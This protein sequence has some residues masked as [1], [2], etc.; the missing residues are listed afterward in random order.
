MRSMLN[1]AATIGKAKVSTLMERAP[2]NPTIGIISRDW[3]KR[4]I[5][6]FFELFKVPWG[7]YDKE[8]DY[9]IIIVTDNTAAVPAARLVFI[10]SAESTPFDLHEGT[11]VDLHEGSTMLQCNDLEFPVYQ[12]IAVFRSPKSALIHIKDGSGVAGIKSISTDQRILRIGYD[13][14]DE[15]AYLLSQGQSVEHAHLPTVEMH[16]SMLRNWI[17]EAG[18]PLLEIPPLPDGYNFITCLTH[19]VDFMGIKDHKFDRSVIGFVVRALFPCTLLDFRGRIPWSRFF[20]NWKAL[21]CLPGV[22]LGLFRDF[23]FDLDRY[24]EIESEVRSTFFFIPFKGEP[25][26]P[27]ASKSHK[28]RAARYDINDY[29]EAINALIKSGHEIGLHGIDAWHNVQRG[30]EELQVVQR[31]T[32]ETNVGVRMHWLYFNEHS[33]KALEE[34]AF[35][36]DSTLGYNEAVGFRSGTTQVFRLPQSSRFFELPLNVMD[37][38]M[39][40]RQR[41][42]LSEYKALQLCKELINQVKSY[43]GVFT[44]NWHTR[45]LSPERNWDAFYLELLKVLKAEKAWFATAKHAVHWFKMRR[46]IHF[47]DVQ[48]TPGK[49]RLKLTSD[50]GAVSPHIRLRIHIPQGDSLQNDTDLSKRSFVDI[51]WSGGSQFE[52]TF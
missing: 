11:G 28:H 27:G 5:E 52:F 3:Q 45:S 48:F 24:Q 42:G 8:K 51:P 36:Y 34:A 49:V 41:M 39:F 14:F 25:G 15:I 46:S 9:D 10:F 7:Y 6:E 40:Y 38:A 32:G 17:L 16:I 31:M 30:R 47:E 18:M 44:I 2:V 20:K 13:L 37:T 22:Y 26:E 21:L 23:W 19:D 35:Y 50:N 12:K 33:A 4:A 1:D 29:K 43:G